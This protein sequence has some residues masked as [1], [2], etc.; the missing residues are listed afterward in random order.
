MA[1]KTE[2]DNAAFIEAMERDFQHVI[3]E[4]SGDQSIQR[5]RD[6]F[7]KLYDNLRKSHENER[8][9]LQKCKELKN[10]ISLGF[11]QIKNAEGLTRG[12]AQSIQT[13]AVEL[14]RAKTAI[15]IFQTKE[16]KSKARIENLQTIVKDLQ[17]VIKESEGVQSGKTSEIQKLTEEAT[18]LLKDKGR[19]E[20]EIEAMLNEKTRC[21]EEK[22]VLA[23]AQAGLVDDTRRENQTLRETVERIE[24]DEKRAKKQ[25]EEMEKI[26]TEK[27]NILN[28]C[29]SIQS[30]IKDKA[31]KNAKVWNEMHTYTKEIENMK[32]IQTSRES[33]N[34]TL[35]GKVHEIKA[36]NQNIE[37]SNKSKDDD[38]KKLNG[39]LIDNGLNLA[40]ARRDKEKAITEIQR[41]DNEI[42][43]A[44][45]LVEMLKAQAF[46]LQRDIE[47]TEKG[48]DKDQDLVDNLLRDQNTI[49][50]DFI[51]VVREN[52]SQ[53]N[54]LEGRN[55]ECDKMN[56]QVKKSKEI[57]QNRK[58]DIKKL[59][60][61]KEKSIKEAEMAIK[62]YMHLSEEIKLKNNL[63]SEFLKKTQ[64][65]E[66][67]LKRQQQLYE[68]VRSDRN[69]YSK[70]LTETQ[71]KIAEIKLRYKVVMHQ[72]S[73]L[74][75]EIDAKEKALNQ[76]YFK[77]KDA[78]KNFQNLKK[79]NEQLKSDIDER[80]QSIM[81]LKNEIGKLQFI[82]KESEVARQKLKR[83]YELVVSERDILGTQL[84]RR[85][86]ELALIY[87]KI[88][89]QQNTLAKGEAEYRERISDID[90]LDN[91]IQDLMR[92]LTIYKRRAGEISKFYAEIDKLGKELVEEKL[93][94]KGLSEE[95]ENPKN[96][97]RWRNLEGS[98]C[99]TN[100]L[101][102][103]IENL[104]K[105]LIAKT[106][107][108]VSKDL[109]IN[110][111]EQTIKNLEQVM[112][113]QPGLAEAEEI[114]YYQQM[115]KSR[116]RKLMSLAAELNMY[117]AQSNEYKYEI[118]KLAAE[119][120]EVKKTLYDIRRREQL[121]L[122]Q[123]KR[124]KREVEPRTAEDNIQMV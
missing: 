8:A 71:D 111:Q 99:D 112:S 94:V 87:E 58:G 85:N 5:F 11:A 79:E 110:T 118:E 96:K 121:M 53:Q 74:K 42:G 119:V 81:N 51:S 61:D 70:N 34:D 24:K 83:K 93:K 6:Q 20:S 32:G 30:D 82:M 116:T 120:E 19:L 67:K 88:K 113:K 117:Q 105:R 69:L 68:A 73:Q 86:D 37:I 38:I 35:K 95:L 9:I 84:I 109:G 98:D 31:E 65:T 104:Q 15:N 55:K 17:L 76:Q 100:E 60:V 97:Y 46:E 23:N 103:K 89:M 75:E 2:L 66:A 39:E 22:K 40:K 64:E 16:E 3:A 102:S 21:D 33:V 123:D 1:D 50:R 13:L 52:Q 26:Q 41:I 114:S 48:A 78:E 14:E 115:I 27:N 59:Q 36:D 90:I 122:E 91:T 124:E 29:N 28:E 45:K 4:M 56:E 7:Q 92:E 10:N 62:K 57:M 107:E 47:H 77:A 18:D 63:I 106:E 101:I 44:E 12:D 108:V 54:E 49:K 72:I 43:D 80:K 25:K